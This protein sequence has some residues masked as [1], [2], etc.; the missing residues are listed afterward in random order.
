MT[1]NELIAALNPF[2]DDENIRVIELGNTIDVQID[3]YDDELP[4]IYEY[5]DICDI[6]NAN[7]NYPIVPGFTWNF[8]DFV[9]AISTFG[10]EDEYEN[11]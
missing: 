5:A 11:E 10:D 1:K 6:L 3:C 2:I 4:Y 7:C 8:N 9:V